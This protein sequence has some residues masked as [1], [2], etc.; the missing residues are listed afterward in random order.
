MKL[1]EKVWGFGSPCE[2][3]LLIAKDLMLSTPPEFRTLVTKHVKLSMKYFLSFF[4]V[5]WRQIHLRTRTK[6]P[7]CL[8][9]REKAECPD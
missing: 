9:R 6:A 5:L 8:G 1:D 2:S 4:M 3:C 7:M